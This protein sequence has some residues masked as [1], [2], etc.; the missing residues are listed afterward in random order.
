MTDTS[1]YGARTAASSAVPFGPQAANDEPVSRHLTLSGRKV[2]VRLDKEAWAALDEVAAR[3]ALSVDEVCA[4]IDGQR[5][6]APFAAAARLFI[7]SY[8]FQARREEKARA[9]VRRFGPTLVRGI[10]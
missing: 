1:K 5:G 8:F 9:T 2:P 10:E 7:A 6:E 4:R 3:E